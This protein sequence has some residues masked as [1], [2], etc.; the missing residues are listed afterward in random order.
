LFMPTQGYGR[1]ACSST[2]GFAASR[3][4]RWLPFA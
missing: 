1:F 3:F 2:L 4:Q